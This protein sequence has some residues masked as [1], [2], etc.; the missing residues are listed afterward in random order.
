M[1]QAWKGKKP[2][3]FPADFGAN[4]TITVEGGFFGTWTVLGTSNQVSLAIANFQGQSIT[5]YCGNVV[6]PAMGGQMTG[7]SPNGPVFQGIWSAVQQLH[8]E[9]P[10]GTLGLPK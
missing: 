4:G 6:G 2:Y 9:A 3:K 7:A 5:S 8:A 1:S 10:A